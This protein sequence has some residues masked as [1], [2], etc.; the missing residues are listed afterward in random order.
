MMAEGDETMGQSEPADTS[1]ESPDPGSTSPERAR[2]LELER[3]A[4]TVRRSKWAHCVLQTR[5]HTH[6]SD[7]NAC[8]GGG[9]VFKL[10]FA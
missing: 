8:L 6:H 5:V 3:N 1:P 7:K 2:K 10:I 4:I 9:H